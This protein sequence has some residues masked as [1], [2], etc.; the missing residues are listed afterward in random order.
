MSDTTSIASSIRSYKYEYGRR[1]HA[2]QEGK[3]VLPNDEAEQDRLDLHHHIYRLM[4]G[5]RL[6]RAPIDPHV[7]RVLDYGTGTGIWAMDF[8]DEHPS[9]VVTGTDLSPIQ[10]TWLPPNCNFLVEDVEREWPFSPD[11]PFDYIHGRS[12]CGSV[13]NWDALF[14]KAYDNLRPGGWIECQEYDAWI[15]KI[16]DPDGKTVPNIYKWQGG[17]D[18]ASALRGQRFNNA[19]TL[20]QKL[21]D[22]G[23]VNVH[24]DI[25]SV[26]P[27]CALAS[28]LIC[29]GPSR[30][31]AQRQE[32]KRTGPVPAAPHASCS[33]GFLTGP[34]HPRPQLVV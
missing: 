17:I 30:N 25:Y 21:I 20:K 6:Y 32:I 8:A 5:G 13:S 11:K 23:F 27:G 28:R 31:V 22:A 14:K 3:Y 12:M 26:C 4:L 34:V 1:Y 9:A 7:Q 33:R 19:S 16:D 10:P 18:E 29:A 24:D 2:Y 15:H